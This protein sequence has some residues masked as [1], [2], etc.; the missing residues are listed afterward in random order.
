MRKVSSLNHDTTQKQLSLKISDISEWTLDEISQPANNYMISLAKFKWTTVLL[1]ML[2]GSDPTS[3]VFYHYRRVL[4]PELFRLNLAYVSDFANR[5]NDGKY[6]MDLF[7][8]Y[9]KNYDETDDSPLI[10]ELGFRL[11]FLILRMKDNLILDMDEKYLNRILALLSQRTKSSGTVKKGILMEFFDFS[12]DV[13]EL[14]TFWWRQTRDN[15]VQSRVHSIKENDNAMKAIFKYFEYHSSQTEILKDGVLLTQFFPLLPYWSFSSDEPKELFMLNVNR[16]NSKTKCEYLMRECPYMIIDLKVNYWLTSEQNRLGQIFQKHIDLWKNMLLYMCFLLNGIILAS[17]N[18]LNGDRIKDPQLGSLNTSQTKA[19]LYAFGGFTLFLI[20]TILINI[21][22][23]KIPI[24]IKRHHE[25][26]SQ[27]NKKKIESGQDFNFGN[28]KNYYEKL[29]NFVELIISIVTDVQLLFFAGLFIMTILGLALEPMYYTYLIAYLIYKSETLI[30]VLQAVWIPRYSIGLTIILLF[31]VTYVF[32]VFSYYYY[33]TQYPDNTCYSLW[34]CFVS[35]YDQTFKTG[36]G[37]GGY[38]STAY[39]VNGSKENISYGRVIY[40][41]IQ[42]LVIYVLLIN[43]ITGIIIDTFGNLRQISYDRELDSKS[44]CFIWE[45]SREEL[46]KIY[47]V[48]GFEYHINNQ[49]NLWDYLFFIAYL[50]ESKKHASKQLSILERYTYEKL[51]KD[52][53]TWLPWYA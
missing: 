1:Q 21:L 34:A 29:F 3:Y 31:I 16:T 9:N 41:N 46:E 24:K 36:S 17:Y 49:H 14:V 11:Y 53:H 39:T 32:T 4:D 38:L 12:A 45:K 22:A 42:Y 44:S 2:I 25:K 7:Y 10:I 51:Q 20:T 48:N 37:I 26:I 6:T 18:V 23:S 47:G 35:S 8:K 27:K 19:C 15:V 28:V 50:Q 33:A 52:D 13:Y 43:L 5:Y 30:N 40:D